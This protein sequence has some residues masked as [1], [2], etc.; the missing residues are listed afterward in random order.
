MRGKI[1]IR[2][3]GQ[4]FLE[5]P[6]N[7]IDSTL[8]GVT[9][10]RWYFS[11]DSNEGQEK[12]LYAALANNKE[13]TAIIKY[14]ADR[15]HGVAPISNALYNEARPIAMAT[16]DRCAWSAISYVLNYDK[17]DE[18]ITVD[19]KDTKGFYRPMV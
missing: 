14:L 12:A 11:P 4:D 5:Y 13:L 1:L 3:P 10:E 19:N 15:T 9:K 18:P 17:I 6:F 2:Q 16:H 7:K 8:A